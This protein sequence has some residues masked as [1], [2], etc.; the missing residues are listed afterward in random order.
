MRYRNVV[1]LLSF[2]LLLPP[3][4]GCRLD[5]PDHLAYQKQ[6][7]GV[8]YV[9]NNTE[10]TRTLSRLPDVNFKQLRR[11]ADLSKT[12]D[13]D[14][15]WKY[16]Q[17][18]THL[19]TD[20]Y[21]EGVN[22]TLLRASYHSDGRYILWAGE[23]IR[24]PAGVPPVDVASFRVFGRFAVDKNSLYFDG[25][26]T[27]PNE[28]VDISTMD[29]VRI[30]KPWAGY[31]DPA[32]AE[33]LRDKNYLYLRGHRA[34]APDSFT[35]QAQKSWDQRG[36]FYPIHPC[37]AR[38]IGPWDTLARTA[39]QVIINGHALDADPDT[40][41]IVRWLP[42]TQFIYRDKNG[43]KRTSL[44]E[45]NAEPP[46]HALS[47]K[48]CSANFNMLEDKV[49]WLKDWNRG[50]CEMKTIPGLDPEQFH[51]LNDSVAQ[52]QDRLYSIK[53]S[54]FGERSLA[55][56]TLDDPHLIINRRFTA[57][58]R[59]GYL[60]TTDGNVAVFASSG[61][62]VLLDNRIP[63]ER[64]AHTMDDQYHPNWFARDDRYVYI[65][66]GTQLYRYATAW[67]QYA[68]V[69]GQTLRSGYGSAESWAGGVLVTLE[70]KYADAYFTPRKVK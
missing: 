30:N 58:K 43:V 3:A 26:R 19:A 69:V 11:L 56:I 46:S 4:W 37:V 2:S 24:N 13:K 22:A 48:D 59:H 51:P 49:T 14:P 9:F 16:Q 36:R 32:F 54:E 28:G 47:R 66:T 33:V 18:L 29:A 27:E 15:Y 57:G 1:C 35:I 31:Y 8:A 21:A 52:Y 7:R 20:Y 53:I 67:P 17:P 63:N 39:T 64:E 44:A 60:L 38:P 55:V 23:V 34:D 6:G 62:L 10:S 61:P 68:H 12:P 41:A 70:G 5:E 42:G 65:F 25:V 45:K 50:T 40:F